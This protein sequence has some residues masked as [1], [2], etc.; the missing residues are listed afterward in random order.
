M[1]LV[2]PSELALRNAIRVV[3]DFARAVSHARTA[4]E[5]MLVRRRIAAASELLRAVEDDCLQRM[6]QL[7]SVSYPDGW[8]PFVKESV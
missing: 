7:P 8:K 5:A 3:D 2:D 1:K 6:E 4:D